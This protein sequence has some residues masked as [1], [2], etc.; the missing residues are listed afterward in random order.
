VFTKV[1]VANR[2]EI[3]CRAIR[4]LKK[5]GLEAIALYSAADAQSLHVSQADQAFLV[6]EGPARDSYLN[7]DRV[8]QIAK[9]SRAE[10]IFPG[11]GFLSENPEFA[12][13]CTAAGLTFIGPTADQIRAFG[14]KHRARGL[15]QAAG[16]PLLPGSDLLQDLQ[17]AEA[18]ADRIG[19]PV[20]LKSTAGGGGI[21]LTV[22][23]NVQDLRQSFESTS[24]L[25]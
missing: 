25:S 15:A 24:R 10:A 8:L 1:L 17:Q 4:T 11:Y 7:V 9:L 14:L 18:E 3:A 13:R 12:D 16:V 20:M 19:Y 5:L 22:C 23:A 2:G 21:G 6:G